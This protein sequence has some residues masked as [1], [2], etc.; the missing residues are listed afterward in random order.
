MSFLLLALTIFSWSQDCQWCGAHEAP[1]DLSWT[2][3]IAGTE[4]RG[5]RIEISGTIF[6]QDGNTP[7]E[8]VIVYVYHTNQN[9]I[10]PKRGDEKGNARR[11]G[12][13]RGWM[14]TGRDGRYRFSTIRPAPYK[15]HGGEPAHIHY[16][17]KAPG[18]KEYW[19][20]SL[21]F[22]DDPRVTK[23]EISKVKR[24]GGFSNVIQLVKSGNGSYKGTRNIVLQSFN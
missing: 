7:A 20:A 21:W 24:V 14:K 11:H 1:A 8:G 12:Y 15:T 6:K 18:E 9:G 23:E 16:T 10:Y 19:L 17:I 5:D 22:A 13:L 2:T 3:T 4:E